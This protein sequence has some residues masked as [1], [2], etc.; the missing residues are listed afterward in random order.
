MH[1]CYSI[2]A[3][4][5]L[6]IQWNTLFFKDIGCKVLSIFSHLTSKDIEKTDIRLLNSYSPRFLGHST[7]LVL[8]FMWKELRPPLEEPRI[9]PSLP[10][11]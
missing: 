11:Y 3:Q 2:N 1:P 8:L 10:L 9:K 7:K 6:H 5:I 4:I